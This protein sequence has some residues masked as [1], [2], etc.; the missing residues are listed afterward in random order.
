VSAP[1]NRSR[2]EELYDHFVDRLIDVVKPLPDG[3]KPVPEA[4]ALNV[5]RQFLKEQNIAADDD[6]HPGLKELKKQT[7]PFAERPNEDDT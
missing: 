4:A 5:V 7:L 3:T 6:K 1:S 2:A